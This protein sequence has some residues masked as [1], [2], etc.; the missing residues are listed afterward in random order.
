MGDIGDADGD[1]WQVARRRKAAGAG[2]VAVEAAC[3]ASFE[4]S[5]DGEPEVC[6]DAAAGGGPD[7]AA[8]AAAVAAG[9]RLW[10][11]GGGRGRA[12]P[13]GGGGGAAS[14]LRPRPS[15]RRAGSASRRSR[16]AASCCVWASVSWRRGSKSGGS[17]TVEAAPASIIRRLIA[18]TSR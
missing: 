4:P 5:V 18:I 3:E 1:K 16:R 6:A 7:A 10:A 12:A 14:E 2:D 13:G 11:R 8:A 17:P 15:E 9:A